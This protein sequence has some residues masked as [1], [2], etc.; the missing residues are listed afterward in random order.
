M[1]V[2]ITH[3]V[4]VDRVLMVSAITPATAGQDLLEIAARLVRFKFITNKYIDLA[5]PKSGA[6]R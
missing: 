5:R 3:A 2:S 1:D 6:P 4:M